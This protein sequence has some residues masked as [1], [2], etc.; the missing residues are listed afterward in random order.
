MALP[1]ALLFRV[2][3]LAKV[4]MDGSSVP[5][6]AISTSLRGF[7]ESE[8]KRRAGKSCWGEDPG[9]AAAAWGSP[10]VEE[11]FIR[12]KVLHVHTSSVG[13]AQRIFSVFFFVC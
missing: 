5:P 9:A 3:P 11:M 10:C 6:K 1:K 4:E 13:S 2:G 7:L 8:R 12:E